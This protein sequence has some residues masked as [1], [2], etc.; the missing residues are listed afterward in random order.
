MVRLAVCVD[1]ILYRA[2]VLDFTSTLLT[3]KNDVHKVKN[4]QRINCWHIVIVFSSR[5]ALLISSR[6]FYCNIKYKEISVNFIL[7]HSLSLSF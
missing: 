3:D 5:F 6:N 1:C 2:Y 7:L 4:Q